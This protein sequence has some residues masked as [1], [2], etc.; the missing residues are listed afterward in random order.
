MAQLFSCELCEISKNTFSYGTPPVAVS[1]HFPRKL[2]IFLL[3]FLGHVC[4]LSCDILN[5]IVSFKWLH[6]LN[7]RHVAE[8]ELIHRC[9]TSI[10][11][12]FYTHISWLFPTP[13]YDTSSF[14]TVYYKQTWKGWIK[15]SLSKYQ[16][17][18]LGWICT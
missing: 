1:E 15:I 8:K 11:A 12:T 17:R 5:F 3:S 2:Q 10:L 18:L 7:S 4:Y 16:T 9:F 13:L 6:V 14:F